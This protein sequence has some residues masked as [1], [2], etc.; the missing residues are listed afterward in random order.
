MSKI[1]DERKAAY[2]LGGVVMAVGGLMFASVFV[3]FLA[4][5]GNF[6]HFDDIAKL[7]GGL[8][9]GGMALLVVGSVVRGVGARGV[10]GSGLKLDPE[11]AREDLEPYAKMTGG[12]INDALSEIK[13]GQ[14]GAEKPVVVK[15]KC[16]KCTALNDENA[17][18][19][20]QCGSAL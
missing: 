2:Y 19:C 16:T 9:F 4:N 8:G 5:F 17:K 18:F 10:A 3:I 20:S 12:L 13:P 7:C 14:A 1:S 15:I 6:S 11:Q